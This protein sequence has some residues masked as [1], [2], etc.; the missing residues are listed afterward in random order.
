MKVRWTTPAKQDLVA[1]VRYI[2]RDKPIAAQRVGAKIR[3]GVASLST[4]ALR[5]RRG[6]VEDTHELV[7]H[8]WPYIAVY[9]VLEKEVQ[10]L[11]IRHAAQDYP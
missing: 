1:I 2:R 6:E 9:R 3:E 4:M 5:N 7:F 10:I 8:P 11:R